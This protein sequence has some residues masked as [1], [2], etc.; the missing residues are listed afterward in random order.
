MTSVLVVLGTLSAIGGF[1]SIPD[2][3]EPMLGM[4]A[5]HHEMHAFHRWVLG[6]SIAIAALGLAAAAYFFAGDASR[7]ARVKER[8]AGVYRVLNNKYYVDELYALVFAR[9][10]HWVSDAIF[11]RL[12]DRWLIDGTLNGLASLAQGA[13]GRLSRVQS[14]SLHKY[15]L[16]VLVGMVAS[17]VWMWRH[18]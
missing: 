17:L 1:L 4:P 10:L 9:P 7:A 11:L 15:A 14:G 5:E 18:G 3:L 16:M 6:G 2:F 8:F 12:G 13:A